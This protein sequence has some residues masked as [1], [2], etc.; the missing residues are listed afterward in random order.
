M[1]PVTVE[2]Q[3]LLAVACPGC[4]DIKLLSLRT[5]TLVTAYQHKDYTPYRM[6][7]GDQVL[8]NLNIRMPIKSSLN[9]PH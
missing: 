1:L 9:H 4:R 3:D 2:D 7:Q 8:Y 5:G 6:C